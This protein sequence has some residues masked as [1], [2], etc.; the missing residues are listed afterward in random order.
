MTQLHA[1][2]PR[3]R[4][5]A[6][7]AG[8]SLVG[9]IAFF[10]PFVVTPASLAADHATDAPWFF[11]LLLPLVVAVLFADVSSGGLD[12]KGIAMLAVLAAVATALRPLGAGVAGLE[13]MFV[14]LLLGGRA[15][16]PAF[17]FAL[18]SLALFT[19]ALLTAGVG[20]WLPFQ[21]VAAGWFAMGAGL[22]PQI[23]GRA[24]IVMLMGYGA[25]GSLLYGLLMNLS[26]WPWALGGQSEL[27]FVAGAP[28]S[29]NLGRWLAFTVATSL[30]WDIPR[31]IL[32]AALTLL[33]GPVLLRAVRRATRRAAFEAPVRFEPLTPGAPMKAA[34]PRV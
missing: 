7:L 10:W 12:A 8:V 20:P 21:M 14:V 13:P 2:A 17:G 23:R 11:A 15:L 34:E 29:E 27:S 26:F 19:S 22:L 6:A 24:E 28:L 30:G 16:G 18:G 5:V 1:I 31:A 3:P 4:T 32:T 9:L 25:V 33:A